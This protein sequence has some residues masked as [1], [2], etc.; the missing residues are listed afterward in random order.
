MSV[1]KHPSETASPFKPPI[2]PAKPAGSGCHWASGMA[3]FPHVHVTLR[4][5]GNVIDPFTGL[6]IGE[7]C[8]ADAAGSRA[9]SWL[10]A[11]A[12]SARGEPGLPTVLAAGFFDGTG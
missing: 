4:R 10:D 5:N 12:A 9:G 1:L 11:E 7:A 6:G 2:E 8:S 3:A